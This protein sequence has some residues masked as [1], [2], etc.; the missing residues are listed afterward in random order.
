VQACFIRGTAFY[1]RLWVFRLINMELTVVQE[2][3]GLLRK[4]FNIPE[5]QFDRN[6][7]IDKLMPLVQELLNRNFE[8]FLQF[9]YRIDLGEEKLKQILHQSRPEEMVRELSTAIVDRQIL[10]VEIRRKYS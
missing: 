9:C 6:E 3:A 10:K 5:G 8:H 1:F 2:S 4:E 7:L